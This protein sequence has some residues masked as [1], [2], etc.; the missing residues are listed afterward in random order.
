MPIRVSA[1]FTRPSANP[2]SDPGTAELTSRGPIDTRDI[3]R[4]IWRYVLAGVGIGSAIHN[5]IPAS[6][7]VV[8]LG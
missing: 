5:W 8:A 7:I 2:V 3:V 4:R 1:S 6:W